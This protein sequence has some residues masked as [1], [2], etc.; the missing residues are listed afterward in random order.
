MSCEGWE[1]TK[2]R[3]HLLLPTKRSAVEH[4]S[5]ASPG[6]NLCALI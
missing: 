1:K 5:I 3:V 4:E 6:V 2:H